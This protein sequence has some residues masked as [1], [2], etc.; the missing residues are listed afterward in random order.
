[1]SRKFP[2]MFVAAL[3]VGVASLAPAN[4]ATLQFV[5]FQAVT[6]NSCQDLRGADD[7]TCPGPSCRVSD[8]AHAQRTVGPTFPVGCQR[9]VL[10]GG[11]LQSRLP[12]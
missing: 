10:I 2:I 4:A 9:S 11:G 3:I 12:S 1:M 7:R 5:Q 8:I 6:I